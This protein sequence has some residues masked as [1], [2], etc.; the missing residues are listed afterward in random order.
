M[1]Q[2]IAYL[3]DSHANTWFYI[4]DQ[5][6]ISTHL[7]H[8]CKASTASA[9]GV[10]N[11]NSQS[12]A[13]RMFRRFM[14]KYTNKKKH[15]SIVIIG[16]GEVDCN[17]T[18]FLRLYKRKI[19]IKEQ[20]DEATNRL[21]TFANKFCQQSLIMFAGPILPSCSNPQGCH[22]HQHHIK[23]NQTA[24]TQ[25]TLAFNSQLKSKAS[26]N[27][28]LYFDINNKLID[29]GTKLIDR[30]FCI[31]QDDHHLN[32]PAVAPLWVKALNDT[33]EQAKYA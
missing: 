16:L 18:F 8:V 5:K 4:K 25:I 21:I 9:L 23:E 24:R 12:K 17:C 28:H 14:N 20:I 7:L 31:N 6:L 11:K 22:R 10:L 1:I 19:K 15:L 3:G 2:R 32:I 29:H 26:N 30:S 27:N 13:H 33:L